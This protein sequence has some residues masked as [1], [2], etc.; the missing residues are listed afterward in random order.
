M[1]LIYRN[2]LHLFT[3][4]MKYQKVSVN[5]QSLLKLYHQNKILWNKSDQ[6]NELYAEKYKIL[7]KKTEDDSE[8]WK[9]IPA[10]ELKELILLLKWPYYS[11]QSTDC[12]QNIL[13]IFHRTRTN[14][15]KIHMEPQKNLEKKEWS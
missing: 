15:P 14:N 13:N 7:I 11:K 6:G 12:Y 9:N 4:T 10:L 8:K 3:P 2:R 1:R 5:K